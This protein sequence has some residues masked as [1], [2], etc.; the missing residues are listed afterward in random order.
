MKLL[1]GDQILITAGKDK[2]QKGTVDRVFPKSDRILVQGVNLYK[3]ARRGFAG[4]PG[5]MIEFARPLY[6]GNIVL[7]C[8]K[9]GK[10]TR[11]GY[12]LDK[13]GEK[14]RICKKCKAIIERIRSK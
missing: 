5:G 12:L 7:L 1:K 14:T 11:V 4:Q 13:R 6:L 9:C 10:Q 2:G 8:P 3:R